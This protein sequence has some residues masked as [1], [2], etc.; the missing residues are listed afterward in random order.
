MLATG[1]TGKTC[2][3]FEKNAGQ[4]TGR[5]EI[6]KKAIPGRKRSIYGYRKILC[7]S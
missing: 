3:R 4:W 2:E 5:V 1:D 6:N 7:I